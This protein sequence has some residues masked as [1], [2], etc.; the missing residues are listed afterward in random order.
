MK[1]IE[2]HTHMSVQ[3]GTRKREHR[4]FAVSDTRK[5]PNLEMEVIEGLGIRIKN[6]EDNIVVPFVNI[7]AFKTEE[8]VIEIPKPTAAEREVLGLDEPDEE[9]LD[10]EDLGYD[11][12]G[13]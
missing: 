7:T 8:P 4:H 10:S 11:G 2:V 13:L 9:E 1:V 3:F 6:E 5:I 12:S